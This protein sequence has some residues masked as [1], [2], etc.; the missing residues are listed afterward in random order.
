MLGYVRRLSPLQAIVEQSFRCCFH[1][2]GQPDALSARA[3]VSFDAGPIMQSLANRVCWQWI[4]DSFRSFADTANGI[5]TSLMLTAFRL[6][7]CALALVHGLNDEP[8][9][10]G[11]TP[12]CSHD[13]LS[14]HLCDPIQTRLTTAG[15][16]HCFPLLPIDAPTPSDGDPHDD[17]F[18]GQV[19]VDA[20]DS[21]GNGDLDSL[22]ITI[23]FTGSDVSIIETQAWVGPNFGTDHDEPEVHGASVTTYSA[24]ERVQ[25][26]TDRLGLEHAMFE[27]CNENSPPTWIHVLTR[28]IAIDEEAIDVSSAWTATA[29]G[30]TPASSLQSLPCDFDQG[31]NEVSMTMMEEPEEMGT[32]YSFVEEPWTGTFQTEESLSRHLFR[33]MFSHALLLVAA[34]YAVSGNNRHRF[35]DVGAFLFGM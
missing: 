27:C 16:P 24:S 28:I 23:Q 9:D 5:K 21:D 26:A 17:D 31:Q 3:L 22:E 10:Q 19:C 13:P 20:I 18:R 4:I 11:I 33:L 12:D 8:A 6:C 14:N 2:F 34:M 25:T 1:Q 7:F 29:F 15:V 35:S 32:P 30:S